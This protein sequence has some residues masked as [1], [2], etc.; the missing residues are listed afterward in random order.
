MHRS[1]A[2]AAETALHVRAVER[3]LVAAA[4][5]LPTGRLHRFLAAQHRLPA[6][7]EV[8]HDR[9]VFTMATGTPTCLVA[10]LV[11]LHGS[12]GFEPPLPRV[13]P[14]LAGPGPSAVV[15]ANSGYYVMLLAQ[16]T[17]AGVTAYEPFPPALD[18]LRENLADNRLT[19]VRVRPCAASDAPGTMPLHVPPTDHGLLEGSASLDPAFKARHSG[20][21]AVE[22][23]T[24]DD[25]LG[26]AP[27][28]LLVDVEGFEAQALAG[29]REVLRT[30]R[31]FLVVEIGDESL[32]AVADSLAGLDYVPF[33]IT[34]GG[35]V[36]Q[37]RLAV[38]A[39]T[40][41]VAGSVGRTTYWNAVLAPRERLPQLR[42]RLAG[43]IP[44]TG[45]P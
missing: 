38:P 16:A 22:V 28:L 1:L 7:V 18:R 43:V 23:V 41:E 3:V 40:Q 35:L 10:Q 29:A 14:A 5:R 13:V 25:D 15:G 12:L 20:S 45:T 2:R 11:W 30:A 6:R 37:D 24:L 27:E 26:D 32:D 42:E 34:P 33:E 21:V 8:T 36:E 31:P 4:H 17:G 19:D 39:V 9:G 44:V